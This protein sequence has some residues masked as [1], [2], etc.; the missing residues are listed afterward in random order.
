MNR[1][2]DMQSQTFKGIQLEWSSSPYR[3]EGIDKLELLMS[4]ICYIVYICDFADSG[5]DFVYCIYG[6][7]RLTKFFSRMHGARNV[8]R[9]IPAHKQR[10]SS[11]NTKLSPSSG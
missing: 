1:R 7:S 11:L 5:H 3:S 10:V 8:C 6:N 4:T 2:E 9:S